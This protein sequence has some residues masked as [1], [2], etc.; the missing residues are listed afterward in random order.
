MPTLPSLTPNGVEIPLQL[1]HRNTRILV[2][3]SLYSF[4]GIA[5]F[6]YTISKS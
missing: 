3:L 5:T 6:P 1:E 2:R 4:A